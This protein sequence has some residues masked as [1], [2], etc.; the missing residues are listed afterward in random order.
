MTSSSKNKGYSQADIEL[1]HSGKMPVQE[2]HALEKAA[3]EDPFLADALEG[4]TFTNTASDDLKKIRQRLEEKTEKKKASIFYFKTAD[5]MKIAALVLVLAGSGWLIYY[6]QP[7]SN[8]DQNVALKREVDFLNKKVSADSVTLNQVQNNKLDLSFDSSAYAQLDR[9]K[10]KDAAKKFE[11]YQS[12]THG[13]ISTDYFTLDGKKVS[14]T[15]NNETDK[16]I[17]ASAAMPGRQ[18]DLAFNKESKEHVAAKSGSKESNAS[19]TGVP[20]PSAN[21]N[22][23]S[24]NQV[25]SDSQNYRGMVS[26]KPI[27]DNDTIKNFNIVMKEAEASDAE[28]VVMGTGQKRKADISQFTHVVIDTLE[29]ADGY[30][31]FNDYIAT[32]IKSPDELNIKPLSGEVQLSFDVNKKGEPVNITVVKSLCDKCDEEAIRLLKEGPKWKRK[33][34]KKGKLTIKF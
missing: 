34:A 22:N 17:S 10:F 28:V 31:Q 25:A 16:N 21:N 27:K 1:Y 23:I 12:P 11:T 2:M 29:P 33:K 24:R 30:S 3:M 18:D 9:K 14:D 19:N 4:Y 8:K 5:W 7:A 20:N 26:N 32:H 6:L 13:N 15:I